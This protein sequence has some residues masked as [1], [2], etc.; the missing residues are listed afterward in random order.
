MSLADLLNDDFPLG[1]SDQAMILDARDAVDCIMPVPPFA[2]LINKRSAIIIGRKGAGKSSVLSVY[3]AIDNGR[4]RDSAFRFLRNKKTDLDCFS[5]VAWDHFHDM[6]RTVAN[7]LVYAGDLAPPVEKIEQFWH[8]KIWDEIFKYYFRVSNQPDFSDA[9][10]NRAMRNYFN[11]EGLSHNRPDAISRAQAVFDE[12][13]TRVLQYLALNKK[14][15]CVLFDNMEEY[16]IQNSVF[17]SVVAGLLRCLGRFSTLNKGI[18]IIFCLPEE[19]SPFVMTSSSNVLKD[20]NRSVYIRWRPGHLLQIAAYRFRLFLELRDPAFYEQLA[21]LDFS[22]R[23]HLQK[24]YKALMPASVTNAMGA[25]ED[26]ISYIIRH[27][28][29]IPRHIIMILNSIAQRAYGRTGGYRDFAEADIIEGVRDCERLVA[30]NVLAPWTVIYPDLLGHLS[31]NLA[32]LSPI[33]SFGEFERVA[34]RFVKHLEWDSHDLMQAVYQMGVLGKVDE[35]S[36]RFTSGSY[37]DVYIN[38]HFGFTSGSPEG[39]PSNSRYCLHPLFSRH[40]GLVRREKAD[41]RAVYFSGIEEVRLN[42]AD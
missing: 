2:D 38:A 32:D 10:F 20:F 19:I 16:P 26:P 27:T 41:P 1:P 17:K 36:S 21:E 33:F 15:C 22:K 31:K 23:D 30:Q 7:N 34:R 25:S 39:F 18:F 13:R 42:E 14:E 29:L 11:A 12:A 40:Y 8:D 9:E 6:V 3:N 24:F 35:T 37:K 28:Q 4:S 5:I